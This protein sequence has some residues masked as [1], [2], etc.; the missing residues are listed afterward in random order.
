MVRDQKQREEIFFMKN[1]KHYPK[2]TRHDKCQVIR[3]TLQNMVA[4]ALV[5][6][7]ILVEILYFKKW[8]PF[9][10]DSTIQLCFALIW[11]YGG[12]FIGM[13]LIFVG[14]CEFGGNKLANKIY[15][16]FCGDLEDYEE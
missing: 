12:L 1:R 9:D 16:K 2:R 10:L 3:E 5:L 13:A 11:A 14:L 6:I 15:N 7:G 8:M 4:I